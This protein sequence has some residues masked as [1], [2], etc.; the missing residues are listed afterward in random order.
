[1]NL[2]HS[3]DIFC[4]IV[5]NFGDIGVCWR[6]A[7]QLSVEHHLS[8]RLFV[9]DIQSANA[10][11]PADSGGVEVIHWTDALPYSQAADVVIEAFAC[12][13][14]ERVIAAMVARRSVWIDLEYLSAEDWVGECHA[15]PSRHPMTG[16][17]KTLFFPGFDDKTG[18]IIRENDLIS[19]RNAFLLDKNAQNQWRLAHFIPEIDENTLDISIFHYKTAPFDQFFMGNPSFTRSIRL[20]KPVRHPMGSQKLG[21]FVELVEVPFLPQFE[22]DY[23]LWTCGF[24]FVRGED[25]FVRAQLAGKPFVWNIYVQDENAHLL[26][27][28]AFLDKIRPF[29]DETSF[30]RLANLHDLWNEG[31]QIP[32]KH[33]FDVWGQSLHSLAGLESG[34]RGWSNELSQQTDLSTQL[35]AFVATQIKQK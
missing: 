31:G 22:Y 9:D 5:D 11:I 19:R 2:I 21:E 20:I 1:M 15:I 14:P 28:R 12:N 35:L 30:E 25:S 17:T 34:A 29:Y 13:L 33:S 7:R 4:A 26:K 18:G 8:V 24:N 16:L 6:L 27:L 10:I 23:L 3:I 32:M